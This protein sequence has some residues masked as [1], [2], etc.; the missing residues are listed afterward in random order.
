MLLL[1]GL[2]SCVLRRSCLPSL[3]LAPQTP[4]A[5]RRGRAR[6]PGRSGKSLRISLNDAR[7]ENTSPQTGDDAPASYDSNG[8]GDRPA[9]DRRR[10]SFRYSTAA[11]SMGWHFARITVASV[12]LP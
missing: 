5:P 12:A 4:A 1:P 11:L 9:V 7:A 8:R 10:G 6:K 2:P 3:G